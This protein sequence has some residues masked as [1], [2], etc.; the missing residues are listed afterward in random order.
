MP[1]KKG[2]LALTFASAFLL[3]SLF[4]VWR[5]ETSNPE[6]IPLTPT[7]TGETEYCLTCH[8]DLQEISPSHSVKAFGCVICHGGERLALDADLAHASMRGGRNPSDLS[9]VEESCGGS[10]C[11]SGSEADG[12][13]HIQRVLTSVQA[14]Y[15]GAIANI[16]YSFGAQSSLIPEMGVFAV[17]DA[18]LPSATGITALQAFDPEHET[19]PL[20]HSFG[21]N[22]LT[23]HLSA[24]P[25]EGD[26]YVRETGCA[27]CHT[28]TLP[29]PSGEG[30]QIHQLTTEISYSQCNTCHN[31]GNYNLRS[32]S[33][34]ERS[35][36]PGDRLHDY[37]QPIAQFTQCEYT[38]D[39][40]DCHTRVESMGD[41]DIHATQ[42][43]IEYV[44]CKTCHGTLNELPLTKTLTDAD[45]LAFRLAQ[46]NP[47]VDLELGDTILVTEKGELLWNIRPLE[48]GNYELVGKVTK[49]LFTF[50]AVM[51]SECQQNPNEQESRY[52]HECHAVER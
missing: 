9:V 24:T 51:N 26:A 16:R 39:C 13:D 25:P 44:Q 15:A 37:Y 12:R 2:S 23:C 35:D 11:H 43:D 17:Q 34:D 45:G 52:C 48:N 29:L 33:F 7:L 32:M 20:L 47:V 36:V 18:S 19:N 31:R 50:R 10:Q 6:P 42:A 8:A 49:Q 30:R 22:C 4:L 27:A 46:L 21:E 28:P 5:A 14:T 38:L 40:I 3:L 1:S 41:G